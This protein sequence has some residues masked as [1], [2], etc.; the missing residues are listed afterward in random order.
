[1]KAQT[2]QMERATLV[3][4]VRGNVTFFVYYVYEILCKIFLLG[5]CLWGCVTF[6]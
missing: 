2:V 4:K 3:S 6:G 1:M 5:R